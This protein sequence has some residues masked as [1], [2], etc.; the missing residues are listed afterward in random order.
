[1]DCGFCETPLSEV[2]R[3]PRGCVPEKALGGRKTKREELEEF[4]V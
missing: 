2:V 4:R 3:Y 1:M